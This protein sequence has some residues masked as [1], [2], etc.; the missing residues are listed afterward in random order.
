MIPRLVLLWIMDNNL[1]TRTGPRPAIHPEPPAAIIL[2]IILGR[3]HS[4]RFGLN[5][6][7]SYTPTCPGGKD[8][9]GFLVLKFLGKSEIDE[10]LDT[11]R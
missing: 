3:I 8:V 11:I 6:T 4:H 2:G 5:L 7:S 1:S 9:Y 10:E